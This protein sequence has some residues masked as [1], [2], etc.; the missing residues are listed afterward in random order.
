MRLSLSLF[1][2]QFVMILVL[3]ASPAQAQVRSLYQLNNGNLI[4]TRGDDG[5]LDGRR[6]YKQADG[7]NISHLTYGYD[8]RGNLLT[9]T[10]PGGLS[11]AA[12]YDGYGRLTS[13]ARSG[14][15]A[16]SHV[17]NGLDERVATVRGAGANGI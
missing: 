15:A 1:T 14:E 17:Y 6:L 12:A 11:I 8:A 16:L 7:V 2:K 13:Y 5:R 3:L 4:T 10:R 9:D